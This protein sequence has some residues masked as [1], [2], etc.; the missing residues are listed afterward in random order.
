M[1]IL[2]SQRTSF[3][4]VSVCGG[5]EGALSDSPEALLDSSFLCRTPGGLN[6]ALSTRTVLA[7]HCGAQRGTD[8]QIGDL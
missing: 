5:L 3:V 6:G 8:P 2:K 1:D 7:G 4:D